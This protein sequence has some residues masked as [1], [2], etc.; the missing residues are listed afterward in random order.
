MEYCNQCHDPA[1]LHEWNGPSNIRI[2]KE[3]AVKY[4]QNLQLCMQMKTKQFIKGFF[5]YSQNTDYISAQTEYYIFLAANGY[6]FRETFIIII[7]ATIIINLRNW[8]SSVQSDRVAAYISVPGPLKYWRQHL[9]G[10]N[11]WPLSL[12]AQFLLLYKCTCVSILLFWCKQCIY[13]Y[14]RKS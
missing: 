4:G 11:C 8:F 12:Q 9:E 1:S 3:T 5:F 2:M 13:G 6:L 10:E 7:S 14:V